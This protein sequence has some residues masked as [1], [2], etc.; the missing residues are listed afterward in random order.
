MA[1]RSA[2]DINSL[3][4]RLCDF[5]VS[6]SDYCHCHVHHSFA[7]TLLLQLCIYFD[8]IHETAKHWFYS[9]LLLSAYS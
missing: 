5:M 8:Y 1:R 9:Y 6:D 2:M 4:V 7:F 3:Y